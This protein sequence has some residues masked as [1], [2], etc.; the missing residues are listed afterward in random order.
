MILT[1]V[2]VEE[3]RAESAAVDMLGELQ[4]KRFVELERTWVLR[5]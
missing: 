4:Q 2:G 5:Q 3:K 1:L